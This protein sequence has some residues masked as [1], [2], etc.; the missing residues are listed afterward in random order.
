MQP[1]RFSRRTSLWIAAI[2]LGMAGCGRKA[3][4]EDCGVIVD[5]Y[6]E[7]E[8]R[9]LKVT[10]PS[11]IEQRKSEMRRELKDDLRT[12]PG[13]RITDSMLT[14]VRLAETNEELDRC[15]RW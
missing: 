7:I 10:D 11:V 4:P 14:C 15:T 3:T 5:R 6:V 1:A 8:L 9:T 12:C 2:A 13:K